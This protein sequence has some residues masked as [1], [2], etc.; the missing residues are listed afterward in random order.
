M[1]KAAKS[2]FVFGIYL[3][4]S[5]LGFLLD[6]NTVLGLLGFP[7]A[8]EVW[9]H[10]TGMLLLI[11]GYYYIQTARSG[12]TVFFH[13]TVHARLTVIVFLTAF[14]LVGLAPPVLIGFGV[15]DLLAAVW[16]AVALKSEV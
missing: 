11:V 3:L 4:L 5:G 9:V 12:I 10:V 14:V 15:I 2:V 13:F 6:P 8:N 7:V 16:T 1:S